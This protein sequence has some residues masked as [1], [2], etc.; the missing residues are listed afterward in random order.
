MKKI[1]GASA[2]LVALLLV[3]AGCAPTAD[4]STG[5]DT[6]LDD[7]GV[8]V[9]DGGDA[10]ET[11]TDTDTSGDTAMVGSFADC[12]A[13]TELTSLESTDTSVVEGGPF[14]ASTFTFAKA[15]VVSGKLNVYI[16]NEDYAVSKFGGLD[17]PVKGAEKGTGVLQLVFSNGAEEV[18][19]GTYDPASGYGQPNWV[20]AEMHVPVGPTATDALL[21]M[22]SGSAEVV[23]MDDSKVCGT[24][25]LTGAKSTA[26]GTFVATF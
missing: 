16:A 26:V 25:D 12:P 7:V 14:V 1:F 5:T 3:G 10:T 9:E 20:T 21:S 11:D 15:K 22:N 19:V 8:T 24:F 17:S 23:A 18:G 2:M 4:E 13:A 6:G